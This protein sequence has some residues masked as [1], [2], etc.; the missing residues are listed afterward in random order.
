MEAYAP[1]W[2]AAAGVPPPTEGEEFETYCRRLGLPEWVI[3]HLL[4][5]LDERTMPVAEA[6]LAAY[7]ALRLP[8][9]FKTAVEGARQSPSSVDEFAVVMRER[10]S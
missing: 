8:E 6:R 7:L 1:S 2:A 9:A 10:Y 5:G 4:E 3:A